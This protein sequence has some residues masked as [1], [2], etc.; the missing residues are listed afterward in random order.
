MPNGGPDNCG[1]CAWNRVT[2]AR[3]KGGRCELRGIEISSPF[4]TYCNNWSPRGRDI[5]TSQPAI[6]GPVYSSGIFEGG[7]ARIPWYGKN[8]PHTYISGV[9]SVTGVK[10]S[11]GIS[12]TD[13]QTSETFYFASNDIYCDWLKQRTGDREGAESKKKESSGDQNL[14][15][16]YAEVFARGW[17]CRDFMHMGIDKQLETDSCDRPNNLESPWLQD[18]IRGA[19]L[20]GAIGD[21]MGRSVESQTPGTYPHATWYSPWRGWKSGPIGTI[22]DDTQMTWWLAESLL[23]NGGLVPDDLAKRFTRKHIR[24]IGKATRQFIAN[25]KDKGLPWYRA[26]VSSS[27]NGAAM[28]AAPIGIFYR[29]DFDELK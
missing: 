3:T 7:Y 6:R 1:M 11:K 28:R 9:C 16:I 18:K 15:G 21:A 12:V 22:T 8:E 27:G 19:I 25:Y 23:A 24:G 13:D 4:W 26:G 10:F 29:E 2:G 17:L 5:P 20:C 14:H